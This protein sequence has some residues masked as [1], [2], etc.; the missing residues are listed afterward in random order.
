MGIEAARQAR[1]PH[2]EGDCDAGTPSHFTDFCFA[3]AFFKEP[4]IT[5]VEKEL[6][7]H[8]LTFEDAGVDIGAGDIYTKVKTENSSKSRKLGYFILVAQKPVM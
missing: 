2:N 5:F 6:G 4:L 3:G 8:V 7:L 1:L